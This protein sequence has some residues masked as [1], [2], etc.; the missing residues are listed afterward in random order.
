MESCGYGKVKMIETRVIYES[1]RSFT[2][3]DFKFMMPLRSL[4]F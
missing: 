3:S 2:D 1:V 4:W